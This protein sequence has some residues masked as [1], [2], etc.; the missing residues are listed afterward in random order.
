MFTFVCFCPDRD[1]HE[2]GGVVPRDVAARGVPLDDAA[3][4]AHG[5]AV[6]ER[7][8]LSRLQTE[9]RQTQAQK[10]EARLAPCI[11]ITELR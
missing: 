6:G 8:Q 11:G 7:R 9:P 1:P 4:Q 5:R 2:F 3:D 10:G